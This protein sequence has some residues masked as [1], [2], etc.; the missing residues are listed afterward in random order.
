[1]NG[2]TKTL[3]KHACLPPS[4]LDTQS[5]SEILLVQNFNKYFALEWSEN[6]GLLA[7]LKDCSV[8]HSTAQCGGNETLH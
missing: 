3:K 4:S 6:L 1:M 5:D 2:L 8:I 7:A